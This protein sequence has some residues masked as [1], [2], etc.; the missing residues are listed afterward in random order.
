MILPRGKNFKV[1]F[2]SANYSNFDYFIKV[3]EYSYDQSKSV[4]TLDDIVSKETRQRLASAKQDLKNRQGQNTESS[5]EKSNGL[6]EKT[7]SNTVTK[8][9]QVIKDENEKVAVDTTKQDLTGRYEEKE[10]AVEGIPEITGEGSTGKNSK[11]ENNS[12]FKDIKPV[13]Y[14][15]V[16]IVGIILLV[17]AIIVIRRR[18]DH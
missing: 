2:E 8:E 9:N 17:F 10:T 15:S 4:V 11:I 18:K 6:T 12:F 14:I 13:G 1:T 16:S 3:P 5:A 7:D